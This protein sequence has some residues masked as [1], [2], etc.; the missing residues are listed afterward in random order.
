MSLKPQ[1]RLPQLAE[2]QLFGADLTNNVI[3]EYRPYKWGRVIDSQ[4]GK[5]AVTFA[6]A[7]MGLLWSLIRSEGENM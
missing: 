2:Q 4:A 3:C 7:A 6:E 1:R 5:C